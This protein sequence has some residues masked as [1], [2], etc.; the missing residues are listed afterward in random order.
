MY[1]D[2]L[3][4]FLLLCGLGL[5]LAWVACQSF[6]AIRAHRLRRTSDAIKMH[7]V[8]GGQMPKGVTST[9]ARE[10][11]NLQWIGIAGNVLLIAGIVVLVFAHLVTP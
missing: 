2:L 3:A 7:L 1:S 11:F 5:I 4:L 6:L 8:K 10:H 9:L